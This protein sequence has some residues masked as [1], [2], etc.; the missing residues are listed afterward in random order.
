[1]PRAASGV[2]SGCN[3]SGMASS[4]TH[5]AGAVAIAAAIVPRSTSRRVWLVVALCA[6][7]PDVDAIGRLIGKG[8]VAWL[9][10]HRALTHSV[11][12]AAAL[13]AVVT[14]TVLR[15]VAAFRANLAL[16]FALTVAIASHGVLDSL[17]TYGEG[18]QFLAPFSDT[19]YWSPWRLLG[20]GIVRDTI[21]FIAF[22]S[23]S[24]AVIVGRRL[25]L[26]AALNAG[27]PRVAT[28]LPN[29]DT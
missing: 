3:G 6:V 28:Y 24:R 29:R 27:V 8:D 25:P 16:W 4:W 15:P 11:P 12:F 5:A 26:P 2:R 22:Y 18:I 23:V 7:V 20:D 21:A 14:M 13:G 9:G 17:T 1:M 10:G 19:R